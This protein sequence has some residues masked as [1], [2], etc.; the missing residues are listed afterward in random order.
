MLAIIR[1]LPVAGSGG[2]GFLSVSV[3]ELL[4]GF[5]VGLLLLQHVD[6]VQQGFIQ[7]LYFT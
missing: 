4:G 7:Y 1:I 3:V 6:L 5:L 2:R